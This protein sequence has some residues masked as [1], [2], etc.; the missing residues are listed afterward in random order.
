MNVTTKAIGHGYHN[1]LIDGQVDDRFQVVK[2]DR[3]GRNEYWLY[4]NGQRW[5]QCLRRADLIRTV[6]WVLA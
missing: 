3:T 1:I 5:N 4:F 2:A 6:E